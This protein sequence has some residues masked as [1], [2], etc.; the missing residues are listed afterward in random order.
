MDSPSIS[1]AAS[2]FLVFV[3]PTA[4]NSDRTPTVVA[5]VTGRMDPPRAMKARKAVGE[6]LEKPS[7]RVLGLLILFWV[8]F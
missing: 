1:K 5:P 3:Y 4:T 8:S 7:G 2:M 6:R